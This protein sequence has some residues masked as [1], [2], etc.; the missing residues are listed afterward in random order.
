MFFN[1][2]DK[3]YN[4]I[5]EKKKK[6]KNLYLRVK[7]DLNI[8]ITSSIYTSDNEIIRIVENNKK[9]I[10]KIL[11]KREAKLSD[12]GFYYLGKKY[13]IVRINDNNITLG[14]DKVF[15]PIDI[16][17][18]KLDNWYRKEAEILFSKY[19]EICYNRFDR[20]IVKPSL[21]IRKMKT[22][23]G[24]CNIKFKKVTLN[25]ELM[26]K[27]LECLEYVIIHELAHLIEANHSKIF[28][29]IVEANYPNY[30]IVRKI[31]KE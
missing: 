4:I 10:E 23:W 2:K 18:K 1:Y 27:P 22:R 13:E 8:Y 29:D 12:S 9:Y 19:F 16:D 31:L 6:T 3:N 11:D 20:R 15:I 5:I 21:S 24:V 25:L 14:N 7:D 17:D 28:W 26:K 30:K